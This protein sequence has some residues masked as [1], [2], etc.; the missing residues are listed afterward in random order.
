MTRPML[1]SRG[2]SVRRAYRSLTCSPRAFRFGRVPPYHAP[3]TPISK[4]RGFTTLF[5]KMKLPTEDE[6]NEVVPDFG[7][8]KGI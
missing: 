2:F 5:D 4:D 7:A 8:D 6:K 3:Y 1:K